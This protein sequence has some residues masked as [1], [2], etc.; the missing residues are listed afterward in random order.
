MYSSGIS[1]GKNKEEF[2]AIA[3]GKGLTPR[4]AQQKEKNRRIIEGIVK[5][6]DINSDGEWQS[7]IRN[8]LEQYPRR[9]ADDVYGHLYDESEEYYRDLTRKTKNIYLHSQIPQFSYR[10]MQRNWR[11]LKEKRKEWFKNEASRL[12]HLHPSVASRAFASGKRHIVAALKKRGLSDDQKHLEACVDKCFEHYHRLRPG[13]TITVQKPGTYSRI[14]FKVDSATIRLLKEIYDKDCELLKHVME[15]TIAHRPRLEPQ[16]VITPL[17]PGNNFIIKVI[18]SVRR[19]KEV[20]D[21]VSKVRKEQIGLLSN[22]FERRYD[23]GIDACGGFTGKM[24][25]MGTSWNSLNG[26]AENEIVTAIEH[27][28]RPFARKG[29]FAYDPSLMRTFGVVKYYEPYEYY[30]KHQ[31]APMMLIDIEA[32]TIEEG[33]SNLKPL[34]PRPSVLRGKAM[35]ECIDLFVERVMER[36]ID[37]KDPHPRKSGKLHDFYL[38]KYKYFWNDP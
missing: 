3:T 5:K 22:D 17:T 35:D 1:I 32:Q 28:V 27:H 19:Y 11:L 29:T 10:D 8:T 18:N 16:D 15:Y 23:R 26:T 13:Q 2:D 34:F 33:L 4:L 30:K 24:L 37:E 7:T 6:F 31:K 9:I 21:Q 25:Y 14:N 12:A 38:L 36:R 20:T